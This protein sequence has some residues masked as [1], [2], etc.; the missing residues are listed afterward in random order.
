MSVIMFTCAYN[1]V[2]SNCDVRL[3]GGSTAQEGRVEFCNDNTWGTVCD[4]DWGTADASVVC[5]QL[6]FLVTE[7]VSFSMAAFGQGTG[8]ILLDDVNCIGNESSLANCSHS[9]IG[10]QSCGHHEDAGVMC[11]VPTPTPTPGK[12]ILFKTQRIPQ[13]LCISM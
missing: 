8:P 10:I 9:G 4:D 5:R 12:L 13:K 1:S 3:V 6:G 11:Q 7:A 2:C